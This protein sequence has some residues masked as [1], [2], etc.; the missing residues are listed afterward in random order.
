MLMNTTSVHGKNNNNLMDDAQ[1]HF[2]PPFCYAHF[3]LVMD[4]CI[5]RAPCGV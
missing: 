3:G 5:T 4:T 1:S 2:G